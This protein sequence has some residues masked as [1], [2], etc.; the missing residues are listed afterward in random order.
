MSGAGKGA[1]H[2]H[3]EPAAETA[4][5]QEESSAEEALVLIVE[6]ER[7]IADAIRLVVEDA[8]YTAL[9]AYNGS[10]GLELA[11]SAHPDLITTDYMMPG[12]N[13][14]ELIA[15]LRANAA[16]MGASVPPIIMISAV[17]SPQMHRSGYDR[18]L[19]KP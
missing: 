8:G 6:D 14:G 5:D 2:A 17:T 12:L 9:L 16:N 13:G 15:A 1:K 11:L 3:H 19:D 10:K 18:F 4:A 7:P